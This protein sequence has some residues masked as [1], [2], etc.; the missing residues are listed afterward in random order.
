MSKTYDEWKD[1]KKK[2]SGYACD[3]CFEEKVINELIKEFEK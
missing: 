1:G 3:Q 2:M